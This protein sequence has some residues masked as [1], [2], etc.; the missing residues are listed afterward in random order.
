MKKQMI[1]TNV[2]VTCK[3]WEQI[4]DISPE[5]MEWIIPDILPTGFT[6]LAAGFGTYVGSLTMDIALGVAGNYRLLGRDTVGTHGSVLYVDS[7]CSYRKLQGRLRNSM[8][9]DGQEGLDSVYIFNSWPRHKEGFEESLCEW[10]D[11]HSDTRL[12]IMSPAV[13]LCARQKRAW[14]QYEREYEFGGLLRSIAHKHGICILLVTDQ[15][16]NPHKGSYA[17]TRDILR[18]SV[19]CSGLISS[20]E[21]LMIFDRQGDFGCLL[22]TGHDRKESLYR[23]SY[24]DDMLP[25]YEDEIRFGDKGVIR[26]DN[27]ASIRITQNG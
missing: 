2:P 27:N 8:C 18:N 5:P 7:R 23:F 15:V 19:G 1:H 20:S 26:R 12:V 17:L 14:Y 6:L 22:V 24:I 9:D 10:L 11:V 25:E 4:K 13:A 21:T 3:R 16:Y